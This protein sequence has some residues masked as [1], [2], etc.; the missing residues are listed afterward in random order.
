MN[1]S[2]GKNHMHLKKYDSSHSKRVGWKTLHSLWGR[3]QWALGS[4][5]SVA[6]NQGVT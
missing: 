5:P 3:H 6:T 1:N 2:V 4:C